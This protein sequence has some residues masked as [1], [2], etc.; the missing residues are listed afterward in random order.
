MELVR[1]V[2]TE[3]HGYL[4][5]DITF[6]EKLSFL[7]GI[8]G[9]GKTTALN[10]IVSLL[11][12]KIQFLCELNF[13]AMKL[14]FKDNNE[15]HTLWCKNTKDKIALGFDDDTQPLLVN[16]YL[17]DSGMPSYKRAEHEIEY[18]N[19]QLSI[20][21]DH[22][23][24]GFLSKLP[25]PMYLG[26]DRRIIIG[27][28]SLPQRNRRQFARRVNPKIAIFSNS[29]EASFLEA[30]DLAEE[31]FQK[32]QIELSILGREFQRNLLME[33]IQIEPFHFSE[34]SVPTRKEIQR[35]E[36]A[37]RRL[38]KLS[39]IVGMKEDDIATALAPILNHLTEVA[40]KIQKIPHFSDTKEER[41]NLD[42]PNVEYL[43]NWA[44]N[45][46]N[47]KKILKIA[48]HIDEYNKKSSQI[49]ERNSVFL[50]AI[51]RFLFASRK[52]IEFD[53]RGN[54]SFKTQS[55]D[56]FRGIESLSSGEVQVFVIIAHLFYNPNAQMG[57]VFIIDEP[58]LSLHI[59]W[60]E[61]FV[62]AILEASRD[63]QFVLATHSPSIILDR[64]SDCV[65]VST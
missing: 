17:P 18:Y 24:M 51:N 61:I 34:F 15:L 59:Q 12:P 63:V 7:T 47:V 46:Q 53:N 52:L 45:Q 40:K 11:F 14:E 31:N 13:E 60:Q 49:N 26:L 27:E 30:I 16:K 38:G 8:N 6:K 10:C 48:D 36:E 22:P 65:E 54:I 23:Y 37:K 2:G 44:S 33:L 55:G 25:S 64:L 9:S 57:N 58:E 42:D 1:F 41:L 56:L 5:V 20:H 39:A 19:D 35:L 21:R 29:L 4:N 3:I 50:K 28:R 43:F 62:D 32:E